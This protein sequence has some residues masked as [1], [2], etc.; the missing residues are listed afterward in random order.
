MEKKSGDRKLK[1]GNKCYFYIWW[2]Y[3]GVFWKP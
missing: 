3:K 1:N 2:G